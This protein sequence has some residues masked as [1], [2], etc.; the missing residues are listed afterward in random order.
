MVFVG[1]TREH[2]I[3]V[4]QDL[5]NFIVGLGQQSQ[6]DLSEGHDEG[7]RESV[8]RDVADDDVEMGAAVG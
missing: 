1:S 8:A 2:G 3:R 7:R 4:S 5:G 6:Q